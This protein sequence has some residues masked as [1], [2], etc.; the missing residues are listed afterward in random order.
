M[1]V[2]MLRILVFTKVRVHPACPIFF[3]YLGSNLL[4]HSHKL[5]QQFIISLLKS[6]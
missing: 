1:P 2:Q 4:N 3:G 5:K 6:Y